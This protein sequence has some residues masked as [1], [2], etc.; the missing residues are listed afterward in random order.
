MTIQKSNI[1]LY[2]FRNNLIDLKYVFSTEI[3][4]FTQ[5]LQYSLHQALKPMKS[6]NI[7]SRDKYKKANQLIKIS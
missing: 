5:F 2:N 3:P 4:K 6:K 1:A 7:L